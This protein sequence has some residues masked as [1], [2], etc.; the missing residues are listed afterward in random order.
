MTVREL[1]KALLAL[2]EEL[3]DAEVQKTNTDGCPECN[4]ECFEQWHH[5]YKPEVY[6]PF[7][8]PYPHHGN[9]KVFVVL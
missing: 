1:A 3:Q 6:G 7:E 5:V 4:P 8:A 9:K 2:P